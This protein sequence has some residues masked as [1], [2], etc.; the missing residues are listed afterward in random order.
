MCTVI[1][2]EARLMFFKINGKTILL[3]FQIRLT[4]IGSLQRIVYHTN[5]VGNRNPETLPIE[6]RSFPISEKLRGSVL[7]GNWDI[8]NY[9]FTEIDA[10]R[11][12]NDRIEKG[13]EWRDTDFYKNIRTRI[14]SGKNVWD[15]KN[16]A[17]LD[18]RFQDLDLLIEKIKTEGYKI[19]RSFSASTTFD[20]IDVNIGRNGEY[21]F[22]DGRHRLSI[23]K[24]L[25]IK[26]VPVMVYVSHKKWIEL[27]EF[28]ISYAQSLTLGGKLYQPIIHPDLS[29]IP[30]D[31]N[32]HDFQLVMEIFAKKMERK[33]GVLLRYWCQSRLF[34]P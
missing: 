31:T 18:E 11:A 19:I 34:L 10:Y 27:R 24:I 1:I 16:S 30:Y 14:E 32:S 17:D 25:G 26:C 23:A 13:T 7:S 6:D 4:S 8:T 29:D 21:L 12:F 28:I 22:Q 9:K 20:E 15:L 3:I 5:Y 33:E 2:I